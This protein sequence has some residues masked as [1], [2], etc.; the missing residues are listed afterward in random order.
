MKWLKWLLWKGAK[1]EYNDGEV[2]RRALASG[3]LS[4]LE[5]LL[6][7]PPSDLVLS[8]LFDKAR[9]VS[10]LTVRHQ[11]FKQLLPATSKS[12]DG[13]HEALVELVD[14]YDGNLDYIDFLLENGASV[15]HENG[16][17]MVEC[18]QQHKM[19][20]S[21]RLLEANV[22][23][24]KST[25]DALVSAC[26]ILDAFN[27]PEPLAMILGSWT[28]LEQSTGSGDM[29]SNRRERSQGRQALV[30]THR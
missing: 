20:P 1:T 5:T 22:A 17:C 16:K 13:I 24:R 18:L 4:L 15:N 14:A 30:R 28:A 21:Q 27:K 8:R 6:S 25:F 7:A 19:R 26:M 12:P 9:S 29:S 11:I 2:L 23:P 10:A 3:S